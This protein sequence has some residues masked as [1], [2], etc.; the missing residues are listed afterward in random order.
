MDKAKLQSLPPSFGQIED[1]RDMALKNLVRALIIQAARDALV[2]GRTGIEA[3]CWLVSEEC[4]MYCEFIGIN[5]LAVK[6]WIRS[7]CPDWRIT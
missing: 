6:A 1:I 2:D 5:F 3:R 4:S 7:G